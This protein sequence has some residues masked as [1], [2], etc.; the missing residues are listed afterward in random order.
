MK[1]R[2][3]F[4]FNAKNKR[5]PGYAQKWWYDNIETR[6]SWLDDMKLSVITTYIRTQEM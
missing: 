5:K 1:N 4:I 2:I 6:C 3:S